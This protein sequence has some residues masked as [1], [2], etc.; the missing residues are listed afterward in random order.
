MVC[1][2]VTNAESRCKS[3]TPLHLY[4]PVGKLVNPPACHVGDREFEPRRGRHIVRGQLTIMV[5][6]G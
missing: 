4:G 1:Y 5:S 3:S 2:L 6:T